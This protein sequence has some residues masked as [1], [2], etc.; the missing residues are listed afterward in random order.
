MM[1]TMMTSSFIPSWHFSSMPY[2]SSSTRRRYCTRTLLLFTSYR[3]VI[4]SRRQRQQRLLQHQGSLHK[5]CRLCRRPQN[6]NSKQDPWKFGWIEE[7]EIR[8]VITVLTMKMIML[9]TMSTFGSLINKI[10]KKEE[11]E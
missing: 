4:S 3:V 7:E 9:M 11:K 5:C 2:S 10:M 8:I 6:S 1:M